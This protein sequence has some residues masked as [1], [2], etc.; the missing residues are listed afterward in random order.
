MVVVL[1]AS[2]ALILSLGAV[3]ASCA[4]RIKASGDLGVGALGA[5]TASI[6]GL[7]ALAIHSNKV[8]PDAK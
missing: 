1:G 6:T 4:I 2:A 3:V 7:T 8:W 5:L